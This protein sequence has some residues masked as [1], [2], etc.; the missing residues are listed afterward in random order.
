MIQTASSALGPDLEG[1]RASTPASFA[2]NTPSKRGRGNGRRGRGRGGRGGRGRG[3]GR[4]GRNE[5]SP[6]PSKKKIMTEAEKE[7]LADLKSRQTELRKFF[8]EVGAQQHEALDLLAT[9]DLGKIAKKSRAHEKVPE[10][11]TLLDALEDKKME[12]EDFAREKYEYG[13]KQAKILLE[14]GKEIIE[15][16]YKVSILQTP[17][18]L[19]H[20]LVR[21]AAL[22][23]NQNI[24]LVLKEII[25]WQ[26]KQSK[27]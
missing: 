27:P 25:L 3:G 1:S 18:S 20:I 26:E 21:L 7:I 5:D 19:S 17:R 15:Q 9:R 6:E 14:A 2:S 10:Y 13:L 24:M 12:A 11:Q 16:R 23:H 22:K 8:K 4:P